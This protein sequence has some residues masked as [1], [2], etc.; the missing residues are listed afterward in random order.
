MRRKLFIFNSETKTFESW[1]PSLGRR[2]GRLAACVGGGLATAVLLYVLSALLAGTVRA[3]ALKAEND[4]LQEHYES[5]LE[6]S[7]MVDDVVEL[8]QMRDRRIYN[9]IF[10]ADPPGLDAFFSTASDEALEE[11][12]S[13]SEDFLVADSNAELKALTQS[14][15]NVD[16]VIRAIEGR[17]G[18]EDFAKNNFPSVIPLR[19]FTL[20][21]TG[22]TVGR[23]VN[24]FFKSLAEHNGIDLMAPYGTEV[25][26]SADGRVVEVL[27]QEKGLGNLVVIDHGGGLR[28]LYAH[29]SDIYVAM[30]QKVTRGKVIGKVGSS[31]ASFTS[32]LHY[33]VRRDGRAMD[34]VNYFFAS[35]GPSAYSEMLLIANTTGQSLD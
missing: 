34:P 7:R 20:A 9:N 35:L 15:A 12:Y 23:K 25:I 1:R 27:R 29:L 10:D 3:R 18:D 22:A 14:A 30:N 31:G 8:L 19:N 21:A 11:Y 6:R 4:Y 16:R 2:L 24:P 32:S 13:A 33:E 5:L 28:T 17:L 26:A